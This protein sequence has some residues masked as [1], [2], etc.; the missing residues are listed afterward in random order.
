VTGKIETNELIASQKKPDGTRLMAYK[1]E[2]I[3]EVETF[4]EDCHQFQG[5]TTDFESL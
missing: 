1:F 3:D 4:Q 2:D 5:F